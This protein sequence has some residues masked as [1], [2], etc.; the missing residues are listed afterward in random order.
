[1][2]ILDYEVIHIGDPAFDLGFSLTHLLSK[3]L[4]MPDHQHELFNGALLYWQSYDSALASPTW[5]APLESYSVRHTLACLLARVAGRSPLE[6]LTPDQRKQ[7]RE[8][9]LNLMADPP[10]SVP[11]LITAYHHRLAP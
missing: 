7:Q 2:I 6:Y 9:V 5:A 4:H 3:A 11:Q 8:I 10:P 1:L